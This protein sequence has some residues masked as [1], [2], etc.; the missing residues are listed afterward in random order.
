MMNR[1]EVKAE[2]SGQVSGGYAVD[3]ENGMF[4]AVDDQ[5][6]YIY[7]ETN[8]NIQCAQWAAGKNGQSEEII[9]KEEYQKKF[10]RPIC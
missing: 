6:G 5:D 9:T 7:T 8:I 2:Q 10:G 3:G 1:T 4:Y